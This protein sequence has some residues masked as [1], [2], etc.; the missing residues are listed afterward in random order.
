MKFLCLNDLPDVAACG[1]DTII[2]VRSPAEFAHDHIP[3]AINLP[4]L[5][6]DERVTVGTIYK[7]DSAFM[8]RK[9]G[10]ALVAQNA[11]RHLMGPL[12]DKPG[13]WQ[14]L[15]YCWRG[16]QRSGSFAT[17]LDQIGWRVQLLHGGY[18]SYRRLVVAKVY[19]TPLPHK[20]TLISGGTGTAK[21][22]LLH[23]MAQAGAQVIDLEGLANHRGSLFGVR[24]GGQ[25]SQKMF[26]TRLAAQLDRMNPARTTWV[27]AE[28][29]KIGARVVPSALWHAM[30][31][32][33]RIELRAPIAAR[34]RFLATAYADLTEDSGRLHGQIDML[35]PYHAAD[36]IAA[37]HELA[38]QG[39]WEALAAGLMQAH[40]DPRYAKSMARSVA[41]DQ[42]IT[43]D[44]LEDSTL[45]QVAKELTPRVT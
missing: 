2:D 16:G 23:H 41:A 1:A 10:A 39:A 21:T 33:P 13:G 11:A 22:R 4:V 9:I 15:V 26:E 43:L 24:A 30:R 37:W 31:D 20:L 12:A 32:A 18:R 38:D 7:Q 6:D 17:I 5:S 19:D 40:Y 42:V 25:P 27:E 29:S 44:T 45:A 36:V 3:G 34:A 8:A 35:R 28:S 14:P